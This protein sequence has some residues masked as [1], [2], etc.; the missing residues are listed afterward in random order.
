MTT[1]ADLITSTAAQPK[2]ERR[3]RR[4]YAIYHPR[5]IHAPSPRDTLYRYSTAAE[6]AEDIERVNR[7]NEN[8]KLMQAV[9]RTFAAKRFPRAFSHDVIIWR[10]WSDGDA[11]FTVPFWRD[12]EDGTQEYTGHPRNVIFTTYEIRRIDAWNDPESG[13]IYNTTYRLG[14]FTTAAQD[15]R[16][17]FY[18]ALNRLGVRFYRGMVRAVDDEDIIEIIDRKTAEPLFVA[19]PQEV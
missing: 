4:Y 14:S 12:Y 15:E 3:P 7:Q 1:T 19:I 2:Q 8:M 11:R 10:P 6:R 5:G 17:A 13:W 9:P 16:R 18:R